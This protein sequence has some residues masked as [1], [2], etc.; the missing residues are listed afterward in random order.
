MNNDKN[1]SLGLTERSVDQYLKVTKNAKLLLVLLLLTVTIGAN[2]QTFSANDAPVGMEHNVLF[3]AINRYGATQTTTGTQSFHLNVLFDGAFAVCYTP[4]A[5]DPAHPIVIEIT[6]LPDK[7]TQ[8]GAWVGW[9]TR[10][11]AAKRFKIEGYN[12]YEPHGLVDWVTLADYSTT[13]YGTA[14]TKSFMQ[15]VP[16]GSYTG[17]RFTF[18]ES[19][20]ATGRIGLSELFFIHPEATTPYEGL[21]SGTGG[22]QGWDL[23]SGDATFQGNVGIGTTNPIKKLD[24]AG[25]IVL[26]TQGTSGQ[27]N[28]RRNLDGSTRGVVG[29]KDGNEN[30][31]F[32]MKV[33]TGGGFLTLHT[34][35]D[36]TSGD[37]STHERMRIT[38]DGEIGIGTVNPEAMLDVQGD[39]IAGRLGHSGKLL[40]RRPIDG[41]VKGHIGFAT[42]GENSNFKMGVTTNE[43][44]LT[45]HT[46][47]GTNPSERIRVTGSGNVGIG[48]TSPS[49]LLTIEQNGPSALR[50]ERSGHDPY[51]IMLAGSKGLFIKNAKHGT[52]E[53]VFDGAGK[54]GIGTSTPTQKLTVNGKINA[55]EIILEDVAGADFVFEEDYEL[56]SLEATEQFIKANKHL[57][58]VPSAAEMAAEGLAIKEMNILLLQKIEELTLHMIRMEKEMTNQ[59]NLSEQT[60]AELKARLLQ[61]ENKIEALEA[62]Q[63]ND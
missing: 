55:E 9:T 48:T 18:Y 19:H 41:S 47:D 21:I 56:R 1:L 30:K 3:D 44:Y 61:Q 6:N 22:S 54:I 10:A 40:F 8:A 50:F 20:H 5:V 57:P 23:N 52:D 2:A 49:D 24:V 45:F 34:T 36:I 16:D 4:D 37:G 51:Q 53:M 14:Q 43:G 60:N 26:G 63:N 7:H 29:F 27:I 62:V 17:L 31:E 12:T 39:M 42:D 13:D 58:E 35:E 32:Q 25:D 28:F 33:T 11:R 38:K 46:H 59:M 15:E